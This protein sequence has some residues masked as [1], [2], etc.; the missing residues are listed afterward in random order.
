VWIHLAS[1]S[2]L[3]RQLEAL[4]EL[5]RRHPGGR[6]ALL[7]RFPLFGV[8][9]RAHRTVPTSAMAFMREVS[10]GK[11]DDE[12]GHRFAPAQRHRGAVHPHRD[13]IVPDGAFVQNLD[14]GALDEAEF[15]QAAFEFVRAKTDGVTAG[16]DGVDAA[17]KA[18]AAPPKRRA[19]GYDRRTFTEHFEPV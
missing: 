14:R 4:D 8:P 15:D 10:P 16:L 6:E 13:G 9:T 18:G 5:Q 12:N 2:E 1:D 3:A 7:Q 17:A 19:Q 11:S